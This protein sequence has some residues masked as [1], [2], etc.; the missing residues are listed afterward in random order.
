[1]RC[2]LLLLGRKTVALFRLL[3]RICVGGCLLALK[4]TLRFEIRE[5]E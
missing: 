3:D 1:L 2:G 5:L 4:G